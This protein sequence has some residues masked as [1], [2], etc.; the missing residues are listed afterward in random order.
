MNTKANKPNHYFESHKHHATHKQG[1]IFSYAKHTSEVLSSCC[2]SF[3]CC[4]SSGAAVLVVAAAVVVSV[5]LSL[6]SVSHHALAYCFDHWCHC[7]FCSS[8]CTNGSCC[9]RARDW[10]L[11]ELACLRLQLNLSLFYGCCCRCHCC[12]W[13]H[14]HCCRFG[15]HCCCIT[16]AVDLVLVVVSLLLLSRH[17]SYNSLSKHK[18]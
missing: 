7:C 16:A 5:W 18:S 6:W 13:H 4:S 8:C 3:S 10:N 9:H 17:R 14:C 12:C 2:C 1:P 11:Q 15:C